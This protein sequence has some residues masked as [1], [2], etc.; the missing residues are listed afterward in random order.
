MSA[1]SNKPINVRVSMT[2]EVDPEAWELEYGDDASDRAA[3]RESVGSYVR[4]QINAS[5][6]VE[7]GAILNVTEVK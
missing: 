6:A 5:T 2:V 4:N 7:S 3:L 1:S